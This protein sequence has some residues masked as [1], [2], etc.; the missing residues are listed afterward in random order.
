MT[1]DEATPF[2]GQLVR[3]ATG[4]GH[5]HH[6]CGRLIAVRNKTALIKPFACKDVVQ[7]PLASIRPWKAANAA[8]KQLAEAQAQARRKMK[9]RK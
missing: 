3:A 8:A 7:V 2:R 1:K 6:T 5:W 4:G 9:G